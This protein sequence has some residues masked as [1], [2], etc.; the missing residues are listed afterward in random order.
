[1]VRNS[2]TITKNFQVK[3]AELIESAKD[4]ENKPRDYEKGKN[5][6]RQRWTNSGAVVKEE[7][8]EKAQV[9][10]LKRRWEFVDV[11]TYGTTG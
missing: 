2:D 8:N 10:A 1:M 11:S 4:K 7:K 5:G 6:Q 3:R 9:K